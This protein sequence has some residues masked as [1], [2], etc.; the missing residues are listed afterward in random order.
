MISEAR[1]EKALTMLATTD[2]QIAE[3]KGDVARKEY[4]CKLVRSK[5]FLVAE[6]S[7]EAR[8]A[9]AEVS[10]DVQAAEEILS[11]AIIDY[12]KL[13]AKRETESLLVDVWR[14][15]NSARSKGIIT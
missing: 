15:L 2:E 9:T 4:L 10:E 7:V 6:G 14:S 11:G 13:R 5:Q 1:L 3:L 12:E 8:K